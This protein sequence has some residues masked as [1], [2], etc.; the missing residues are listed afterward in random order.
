MISADSAF[1]AEQL[2]HS[3]TSSDIKSSY[4]YSLE[5]EIA[6]RNLLSKGK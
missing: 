1:T 3:T 2:V 5:C 6:L 4:A